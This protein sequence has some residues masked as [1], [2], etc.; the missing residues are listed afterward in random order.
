MIPARTRPVTPASHE[1]PM[2][3]VA[4]RF[5]W[6]RDVRAAAET[7]TGGLAPSSTAAVLICGLLLQ[8][9]AD[10]D[11]L[12]AAAADYFDV[13]GGRDAHT[14]A[15]VRD[16]VA[17]SALRRWKVNTQR[18]CRQ[19]GARPSPWDRPRPTLAVARIPTARCLP[20]GAFGGICAA[21]V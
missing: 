8:Q 20:F 13:P 17:S 18:S 6:L 15:Q 11:A 1:L 16:D 2:P 21:S 5:R 7:T 3:S 10:S 14:V 4:E 19:R 12:L 9:S